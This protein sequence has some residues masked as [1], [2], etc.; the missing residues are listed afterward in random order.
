VHLR[1]QYLFDPG[2]DFIMLHKVTA[3]GGGNANIYGL[4]DAFVIF[5]ISTENLLRQFVGFRPLWAAI[6]ARRAS[7]S[8]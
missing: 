3:I 7:F 1:L 8:G 5:Q 2:P 4:D 6:C